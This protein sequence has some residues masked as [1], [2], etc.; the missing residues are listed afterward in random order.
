MNPLSKA[1]SDTSIRNLIT[2][3]SH[4]E[5]HKALNFAKE[6]HADSLLNT[7]CAEALLHAARDWHVKGLLAE[8]YEACELVAAVLPGDSEAL[9][10]LGYG[11]QA[12]GEMALAE[13]YF[14]R[15]LANKPDYAFAKLA[16]AQIR[17]LRTQFEQGRDLYEARFDAVTEGSGPDWRGL[18]IPRW[19]GE[20]LKGKKIYLW[21]EQGLGDIVMF[22]GFLPFILSQSPARVVLGMFPKLI[23]LFKRSFPTMDIEPI[24]DVIHHA[25]GPSVADSFPYIEQL[26]RMGAVPFSVEPLRAAYD[27]VRRY[28]LFDFAAPLGDLLVHAMPEFIP[29]RQHS[30][31]T[32]D[33]AR[34]AVI[35]QRL[36]AQGKGRKVGIS[37]HTSNLR[38]PMRNIPLEHWLPLLTSADCQFVSLQHGV[39]AAEI[40]KFCV[41]YGCRITVDEETDILGNAEDLAALIRAMDAVITI[42]NSNAHLAGALGMPT[43]VLLPK[44]HNYRWPELK[45]RKTLWYE[46]VTAIR[47]ND[48]HSWQSVINEAI[49]WLR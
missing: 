24:D 38:E 6:L 47:Q 17:M 26:S 34:V 11:A 48:I 45:D 31:L 42:D 9:Q 20:P 32:A 40:K 22:A 29:A 14:M 33:P 2:L 10:L 46:S 35:R 1:D 23:S 27:Y 36:H 25:L 3:L 39:D 28:G 5:V 49:Q 19:R 13:T 43:A 44:G 21:A 30:Y 7:G 41:Q 4:G 37:W 8:Q 15:A 16:F 18:P 12:R